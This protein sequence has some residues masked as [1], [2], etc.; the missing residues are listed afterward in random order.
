M[1]KRMATVTQPSAGRGVGVPVRGADVESMLAG[2]GQARGRP[3]C[4]ALP[5]PLDGEAV[6]HW[7]QARGG[8]RK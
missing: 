2:G 4:A 8:G 7:R 3:L 6:D 1:T 5:L